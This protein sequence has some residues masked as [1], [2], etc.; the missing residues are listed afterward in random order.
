[1]RSRLAYK[2]LYYHGP[3]WERRDLCVNAEDF[4][5]FEPIED[6][7]YDSFFSFV[8]RDNTDKDRSK[9]T[10]DEFKKNIKT[11]GFDV[12]SINTL[13]SKGTLTNPLNVVKFTPHTLARLKDL[14]KYL[15]KKGV[16]TIW[17]RDVEEHV[18][19]I[20]PISTHKNNAERTV[21]TQQQKLESYI[22][23]IFKRIAEKL[24]ISGAKASWLLSLTKEQHIK[25]YRCISAIMQVISKE[26]IKN[27]YLSQ[28]I[29][30]IAFNYPIDCV[31]FGKLTLH[32]MLIHNI[33]IFKC[34]SQGNKPVEQY[35]NCIL[36]PLGALA[37]VSDA[38]A[39]DEH[40][41]NFHLMLKGHVASV[42]GDRI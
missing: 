26:M 24:Y 31:E 42:L 16:D 38:A 35:F 41:K 8:H 2:K 1:M 18:T 10:Y 13:V 36:Y 22:N 9:M 7:P 27:N 25:F 32:E 3:A 39:K 15:N 21:L 33:Y 28:H 30:D 40:V 23:A 19:T 37:M 34:M 11:F 4:Y 14:V 20:T 5:S 6:I 29:I 12:K 17:K